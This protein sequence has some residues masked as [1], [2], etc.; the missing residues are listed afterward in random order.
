MRVVI[1]RV[2]HSRVTVDGQVVGE[3]GTGLSLLVGIAHTDTEAELAWMARKCLS[4]RLFSASPGGRFEHSIQDVQGM[5]LVVSQFT[6]YGD[7]QR[8]R[9]P[10]F[11]RAAS[12]DQARRQYVRFVDLLKKSGLTVETGR[13]GAHMQVSFENDGPVTLVLEREAQQ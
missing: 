3:I 8:G 13:F 12:P 4:L 10:S 9:R 5:L 6:L 7:C 2:R 1:Q 11:D